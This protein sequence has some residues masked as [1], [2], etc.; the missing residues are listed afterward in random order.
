MRT[1]WSA[2][3]DAKMVG[4][5]G[6]IARS[7]MFLYCQT[8]ALIRD[9]AQLTSPC[10]TRVCSLVSGPVPLYIGVT[11]RHKLLCCDVEDLDLMR[12]I[13][14]H[15]EQRVTIFGLRPCHTVI[16]DDLQ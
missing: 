13:T 11:H 7:S 8:S 15:A 14:S 16:V 2:L 12:R 9:R 3:P 10:P 6:D 5:M 1:L 4:S